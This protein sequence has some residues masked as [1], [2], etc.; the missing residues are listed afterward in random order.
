MIES[1]P[2]VFKGSPPTA[3]PPAPPPP[4]QGRRWLQWL[5]IGLGV[6]RWALLALM[7]LIVAVFGAALASA[8]RAVDF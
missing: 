1:A 3:T 6:K 5:T 7:G 2:D 4:N 8:Y